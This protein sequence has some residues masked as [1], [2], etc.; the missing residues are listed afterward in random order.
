MPSQ[1]LKRTPL[2][3]KI[4]VIASIITVVAGS[5]TGIM[6]Y[7]NLGFTAQFYLNWLTSFALA[8]CVML[9]SGYVMIRLVSALVAKAFSSLSQLKQN[10]MIGLMMALIME[11]IMAACT[12]ANTI[13]FAEL[14]LY[15]VAWRNGLLTALPIGLVLSVLMTLTIK[16]KL[17]KFMAS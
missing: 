3:Q 15:F 8:V 16:P 1:P 12:A 4:L 6:T 5:L 11:S 7:V 13:G 9:P 10:I 14:E 17:E 2:I